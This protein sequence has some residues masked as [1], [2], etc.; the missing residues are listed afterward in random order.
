MSGSRALAAVAAGMAL[1]VGCSPGSSSLLSP[2]YVPSSPSSRPAAASPPPSADAGVP[3]CP[4][5]G[6]QAAGT[7]SLGAAATQTVPATITIAEGWDGCGLL[8]KDFGVRGGPAIIG[9]WSVTN[10]YAD[11]C[12][13]DG[14][15]M[16]PAVGPS[17]EDLAAA[18][19]DQALTDTSE[20]T[21]ATLGGLPAMYVRLEVPADVD[22]TTCNVVREAEFRF[23]NG[24]GASV[25]WLGARDA[26]GL[27]GE[28]WILEID[29][30]RAVVQAA[31]FSDAGQAEI[32]E[33][34]RTIES[35]RFDSAG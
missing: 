15:L 10:V 5:S 20:P 8:I 18:L 19:A 21:D 33:I 7:F 3:A 28:V 17:A 6:R 23:W 14:G 4:V 26:P 13:W 12:H 11:P 34:H 35:I 31:Y 2:S 29:G 9:L 24:P 25:W 30:L 16:D 27:I 22:V 32:D 1:L